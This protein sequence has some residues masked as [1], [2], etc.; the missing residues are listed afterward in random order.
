MA[1]FTVLLTVFVCIVSLAIGYFAGAMVTRRNSIRAARE[2]AH[3]H[4]REQQLAVQQARLDA[5]AD[6]RE[7]REDLAAALSRSEG[8][9]RQIAQIQANEREKQSRDAETQSLLRHMA[10]MKDSLGKLEKTLQELEQQRS[11]QHGELTQQLRTA[12]Q[13]E[14]RLR[15]TAESL[16]AALRSGNTRGQW[17]EMQLRRVVEASGMVAHLDFTEQAE[18]TGLE[19]KARP[20]LVVHLPGHKYLA[21]DAKVPFTK[22]LEAEQAKASD[23]ASVARRNALLKEHAKS[24]R[25]HITELAARDYPAALGNSPQLVIAFVPSEPLLAAALEADPTI[26]DFA[27][28]NGVALTSPTTLWAVLKAVAHTW[29]Q[30]SLSSEAQKLFTYSRELHKRLGTAAAHLDR[31]GSSLTQNVKH[32]NAFVGSI[33]R[34][35]L[36][37]A[38][39]IGELNSDDL[40][41]TPRVVD[42]SI[43]PL[44][45]PELT[46]PESTVSG[47]VANPA[48]DEGSHPVEE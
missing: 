36:S 23:D 1:P 43:R 19:R 44:T 4:E 33:E 12:A 15:G 6:T 21:V 9:E 47:D 11:T 38:R 31:L 37:S 48:A 13:S 26:L 30:E 7:I 5:E 35:V 22:F 46:S 3:Q 10:P 2:R 18:Y 45:A 29:Q 34:N 8:L 16:A 28:S 39:K 14:E 24:L 40:I 20:D 27:Y 25:S 42:E 41:Q 17:G 32:Y